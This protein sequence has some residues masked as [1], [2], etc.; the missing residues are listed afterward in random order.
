MTSRDLHCMHLI[1]SLCGSESGSFLKAFPDMAKYV[2]G[3]F[4]LQA[5][6]SLVG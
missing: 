3:G 1:V 5:A 2:V 4:H 6:P